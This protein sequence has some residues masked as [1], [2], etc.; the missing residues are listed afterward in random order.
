MDNEKFEKRHDELVQRLVDVVEEFRDL[1]SA[2]IAHSL[3][4]SGVSLMLFCAPRQSIGISCVT[5]AVEA[6][7]ANYVEMIKEKEEEDE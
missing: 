5:E 3:I 6:G 7:V 1:S 4:N 2:I